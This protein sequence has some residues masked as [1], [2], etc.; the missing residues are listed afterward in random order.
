MTLD[1]SMALLA[2]AI[3]I[4]IVWLANF[5]DHTDGE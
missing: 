2:L 1:F 4:V 3:V 5:F